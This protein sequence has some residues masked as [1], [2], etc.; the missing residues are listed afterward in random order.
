V[1]AG[2]I[3]A[4]QQLVEKELAGMDY[5]ALAAEGVAYL[6]QLCGGAWTD[7]YPHDPGVTLLEY[8][9]YAISDLCYR[10]NFSVA[11]LTATLEN[12]PA[13]ASFF[14]AR[15]ILTTSPVT[16]AD[17]RRLLID[18]SDPAGNRLIKNAWIEPV[19]E[20]ARPQ[21]LYR[22]YLDEI[23]PLTVEQKALLIPQTK[24]K[25]AT[26]RNL[27]EDFQEII[28][29]K[30]QPVLFKIETQIADGIDADKLAAK[31][32]Y[33]LQAFLSPTVHFCSKETLLNQGKAVE[34]IFNGPALLHGFIEDAE[35]NRCS[36][37]KV[38]R[39]SNLVSLLQ[40]LPGVE[41]VRTISIMGVSNILLVS[42]DT[43][44]T[45]DCLKQHIVLQKNND[46]ITVY[47]LNN[48]AQ[49]NETLQLFPEEITSLPEFPPESQPVVKLS[50][51]A[52]ESLIHKIKSICGLPTDGFVVSESLTVDPDKSFRLGA[53]SMQLKH[54]SFISQ[55]GSDYPIDEKMVE[56]HLNS[57][58]WKAI[59][60]EKHAKHDMPVPIGR[61][62]QLANYIS[63][64]KDLPAY[65]GVKATLPDSA[66]TLKIAQARQ[67]KAYFLIFD[68]ILADYCAQLDQAKE[69]LAVGAT[70]TSSQTLFH[71]AVTEVSELDKL[72]K[73]PLTPQTYLSALTKIKDEKDR[74]RELQHK[75]RLLD[76]LLARY[77]EEFAGDA[78]L[79]QRMFPDMNKDQPDS[80]KS[81]LELSI[82]YKA[83][84]LKNYAQFS[85]TRGQAFNYQLPYNQ[86][87]CS[88][89]ERLIASLLGTPYPFNTGSVDP[90]PFY[91]IEHHLLASAGNSTDEND[92][93]S[94]QVSFIFPN[95]FRVAQE[96]IDEV[97]RRQI[98]AHIHYS[99]RWLDEAQFEK[100]K[101]D[102][103]PW[104]AALN[105]GEAESLH[106]TATIIWNWLQHQQDQ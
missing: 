99:Y 25:L 101:Q 81:D 15:E 85:Y 68:Q 57:L 63:I 38:I 77:Y 64:Q 55:K 70:Q 13:S 42:A 54:I 35:L 51:L 83:A 48:G 45:Y 93:F 106:A 7:F 87:N 96:M 62:R 34:D 65:Y 1:V 33:D 103:Q 56:L 36:R 11:D 26:Q 29:L 31:I 104:V 95:K 58:R 79:L 47:W 9:C 22:V 52:H 10:L 19:K 50:G 49:V 86:S 67:L 14:T 23:G 80:G 61:D 8:L 43:E 41:A 5:S 72:L 82:D 71:Q 90:A 2:D 16:L 53:L 46:Q 92:P 37:Q 76:H 98:P 102:L 105:K 4:D 30:K 74:L 88:S 84:F 24:K 17:Y 89:V 73:A 97:I 44:I 40:K 12:S 28:L 94:F 59:S 3:M 18:V 39:V 27:C 91:L 66:G 20:P 6:R 75:N 21:G 32:Y 100:F 78:M 69:L 60:S